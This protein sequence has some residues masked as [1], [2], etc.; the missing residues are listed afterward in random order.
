[1][2]ER[3][4]LW[5]QA[6]PSYLPLENGNL[7]MVAKENLHWCNYSI[8]CSE[9]S[10]LYV[11]DVLVAVRFEI[12]VHGFPNVFCARTT[13]HQL[14][15]SPN[16]HFENAW[17]KKISS[18]KNFTG[19]RVCQ[20]RVTW[21]ISRISGQKYKSCWKPPPSSLLRPHTHLSSYNRVLPTQATPSATNVN[22][23]SP[24]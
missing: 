5:N 1:M 16:I 19:W 21:I 12:R 17:R 22:A 8:F 23:H 14:L 11:L 15:C 10:R 6:N 2:K 3:H 7:K 24:R 13:L 18:S 20:L 4:C 9:P